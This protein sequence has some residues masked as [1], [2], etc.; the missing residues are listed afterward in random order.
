M[1]ATFAVHRLEAWY[2]Q[3]ADLSVK[4]PVL[5]TYMGHKNLFETQRY[6]RLTAELF[7]DITSRLEKAYGHIIP[8]IGETHES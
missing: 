4:L 5:S 7:P 6:L 1:R 3:G 8:R 2:L